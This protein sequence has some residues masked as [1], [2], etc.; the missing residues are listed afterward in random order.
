MTELF[1]CRCYSQYLGFCY[2]SQLQL[3][4]TPPCLLSQLGSEWET[5]TQN[6]WKGILLTF[7][8]VFWTDFMELLWS[9]LSITSGPPWGSLKTRPDQTRARPSV[10]EF[11]DQTRI[12]Q[13]KALV[14]PHRN[15]QTCTWSIL[16]RLFSTHNEYSFLRRK[17]HLSCVRT[18][19]YSCISGAFVLGF[20]PWL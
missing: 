16:E 11:G 3:P 15:I 12:E 2:V 19:K 10:R 8:M 6:I 9:V 13:G 17:T 14:G 4:A 20:C 5:K 18:V 7:G 1:Q